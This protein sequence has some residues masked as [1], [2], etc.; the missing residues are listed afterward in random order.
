MENTPSTDA[1][2]P[3]SAPAQ[4]YWRFNLRL[5]TA[6]LSIWA[7]VSLGLA[8]I[9][10]DFFDRFRIGGFPLGFWIAH[11]GSIVLFVVLTWVYAIAMNRLDHQ[12]D[13]DEIDN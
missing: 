9:W 13:V 6:L 7:V 11:Q 2:S 1:T 4:R 8:T 5:L 12:F 3:R 10:V